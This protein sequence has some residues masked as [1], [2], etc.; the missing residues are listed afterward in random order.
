MENI[1]GQIRDILRKEGI[2]GMA[3]INHCIVFLVSRL[4]NEELCKKVGIASKYSFNNMMLDT[5]GNEI[6]SQ[7]L[8]DKFYRKSDP[9]FIR[10]VINKLKFT[11]IKFKMEGIHNLKLIMKKLEKLDTDN[12]SIKYDLIG[13]IY[14]IHLKSGTSNAMRDLGQYYTHRLVIKYMIELCDVKMTN[15]IIEKIVDP[16][17]GTG[18]FLTM[19]IKDLQSKYNNIDWTKNKDNIIGFDI[20]DNVKN[21]A[22]LNIFLEIGE[23]CNNTVVKQ[24][25]LKNDLRLDNGILE[26]AKVILANEPMG[27]K[28]ITHASCCDRIK[29]L[30]I[31]GTKAEPLFLQLFMEALD[32]DGRC[33][34]I[35]P[36]GVLFTESNLH[37]NTRKHMI[38]NFN[39]KKVISLNDDNFF[40]NTGVSTSILFFAK[41]GTKTKKIEFCEITLNDEKEIE[42]KLIINVEYDKIKDNNYSLFVNMYN[43]EE[44]DKIEGLEYKKISDITNFL[45]KSK[46]KASYG[47]DE[48]MFPFYTSSSKIKR[49]NTADYKEECIII[50]DGGCANIYIDSNFSCSDHN[51]IIQTKQNNVNNRFLKYYLEI[52]IKLLELGF[53]G[54]TIKNLS[55]SYIQNLEIPIPSLKIQNKIIEQLDVLSENNNTLEKNIDEFK[56][57]LKYYVESYTM[58]C[59]KEKL[60]NL[61]NLKAGKFNSRDCRSKGKYPFYNGKATNPSGFNDKFC[62]DYNNYLILIK[63]GGAGYKKYGDQIG[64]G[65]VFKV[66]GKSSA[67]SHQLALVLKKDTVLNEYLYYYLSANKNKIMDLALYTTGLGTIRKSK[68][69]NFNIHIPTKEKQEHIVIYCDNIT[70]MIE[71]MEQ[72][73]IK[74]KELMK[75]ILDNHLNSQSEISENNQLLSEDDDSNSEDDEIIDSEDDEIIDSEDNDSNSEDDDEIIDSEDNDSNSEDDDEIINNKLLVNNI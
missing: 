62:F 24:D 49:C 67:T 34:V 10:E 15:G 20:D 74:N 30:K 65:K 8:Y 68:L 57:I 41:D 53:K 33:A 2:T 52:N 44:L 5:D 63:D 11:N 47:Q 50:G 12:L 64:L 59:E 54:A 39:L 25:T 36:D 17:M 55:K 29:D 9:C 46:R 70:S 73:I 72:Q 16:T 31:R 56:E 60:S 19:V 40:L 1:I 38:E 66:N 13:T 26:K 42:E 58:N 48:G 51:H 22:L 14:E 69:E 71:N 37:K 75:N 28:N 32:D 35:V 45:K 61:C 18:G 7:D 21:M 43:V 4:L 27:I 6:G 23:V 3:S